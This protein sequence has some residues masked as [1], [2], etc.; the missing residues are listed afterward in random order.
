MPRK[1]E[2]TFQKGADGRMGRW[3]KFYRGKSHY[4]GSGRCKSDAEGYR[5]A[6]ATWT[7]LKLK[8]DAESDAIPRIRD[9]E[10]DEVIGEWELVLSWSVQHGADEEAVNAR[11][12]LAALRRRR[13]MPIQPPVTHSDR[14]WSRF[15]WDPKALLEIGELAS[16]RVGQVGMEEFR[17]AMLQR[18][19]QPSSSKMGLGEVDSLQR[20]EIQWEDR[21]E[22]QRKVVGRVDD[23]ALGVW[24]AQYLTKQQQ[25]VDAGDLSAGRFVCEKAALQHFRDWAGAQMDVT[26]ISGPTLFRF[27]A[28]QLALIASNQCAPSYARDRMTSVRTFIRWLWGQDMI[29]SLP[30]NID[31]NEL[32]IA[33]RTTA[34]ETFSL[35]EVTVLLRESSGPTRLY[36]L[37]GLNCGMTQKDISDLLQ[38]DVSW[39][40]GTITR[41]RSKTHKHVGVPTVTYRLWPETL[42]LLRQFRSE[43]EVVLLNRN[44]KRLVEEHLTEAGSYRKTDNIKNAYER[45]LHKVSF[46][47][48]FKLLRKTSA[49]LI[50]ADARSRGLDQLFLGHAPA[51]IAEKHYTATSSAALDDALACLRT[52][53]GIERINDVIA[54]A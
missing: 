33:R 30:K 20:E 19:L 22:T 3:K 39:K 38:V 1:L 11:Q 51:T 45:V 35:A 12:I 27:H 31:S 32:K 14:F 49:T 29:V 7:S 48:P 54:E 21:L 15:R 44:G 6:L 40:N 13:E 16:A 23:H 34:P 25:R 43:S 18:T 26:T 52:N 10:Y 8:L 53:Y 2:L 28:H 5:A 24:V 47:K 9:V 41:K 42:E 36:I 46:S 17:I 37:L 4:V 50:N